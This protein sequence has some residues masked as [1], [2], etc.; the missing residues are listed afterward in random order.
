MLH[1]GSQLRRRT[2]HHGDDEVPSRMNDNV[3][4]FRRSMSSHGG[5]R[6]LDLVYQAAEV[7]GGMEE[8]A[9]ET[10]ARAQK[11]CES[12]AERI[13]VADKRTEAAEQAWREVINSAEWK[14]QAA[15]KALNLA[16]ARIEAAED[17]VTALEFRAQ[18]AEA[19]LRESKQTLLLVEEAI[20]KRLLGAGTRPSSP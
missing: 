6:A 5:A 12:A 18:A 19:Q 17:K 2:S 11:L 10:E 1:Q 4:S 7:F 13:R 9:R 15:S 8:H 16:Q 20:Q 14:L 3:L